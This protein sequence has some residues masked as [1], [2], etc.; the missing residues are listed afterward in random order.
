MVGLT[1]ALCPET[2]G[3]VGAQL[4]EWENLMRRFSPGHAVAAPLESGQWA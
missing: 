3:Y 1:G 2:L 4:A